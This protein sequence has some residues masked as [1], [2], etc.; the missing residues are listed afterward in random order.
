MRPNPL[1]LLS[2]IAGCT[3]PAPEPFPGSSPEL[4]GRAAGPAQQCI[5][6]EPSSGLR[7]AEG[8]RHTL[9]SGS[10]RVIYSNSLGPHCSFGWNDILVFQPLGTQ[11]CRGDIVR[12]VDRTSGIPGPSCVLGDFVP[13]T[14]I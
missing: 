13:H 5:S 4:A 10:G 14:R 7:T 12:S 8:D 11:Y 2:L 3:A 6:V 9:L 1:I